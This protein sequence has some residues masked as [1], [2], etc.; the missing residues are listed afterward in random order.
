MSTTMKSLGLDQLS[1]GERIQLV[2]EIW[3]SIPAESDLELSDAFKQEL[4]R[5]IAAADANPG[6]GSTWEEVKARLQGKP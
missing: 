4:D 5:R 1:V 3:D 2:Q 6:A